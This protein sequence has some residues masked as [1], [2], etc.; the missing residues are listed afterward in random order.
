MV[1]QDK[2][3]A[4]VLSLNKRFDRKVIEGVTRFVHESGHWS[5]FLEDDPTA[6]IPDFRHGHFDG[7]IADLDDPRIPR[8]V[9]GL[10]MPVVGIGGIESGCALNLTVSTV[11]TNNHKIA[12]MAAEYLMRLGLRSFGYCGV[13]ASTID[14]WNRERQETFERQV[15]VAGHAC[16]IFKAR[17]KP[18]HSWEQ[19]QEAI[20]A[21][22]DPL[23]KPVGVLA[24]NDVRARHVLEA[25]RRFGFR[26]PD[27]VAVLGVD[28]D[29]LI[30]DLATPPLSSIVQG[31]EEIGYRAAKL[32]DALMRH[33]AK[34]V[35]NILVDPVTIA[36]RASTDL[37][38]T[39]DRVVADALRL[40]RQQACGGLGVAQVAQGIGVSRSTL[41]G[42]FRQVVGRSVHQEILRVQISAA[43]SLLATTDLSLEDIARRAGFCH[44]Q[45]L[46]AIFRRECGQTPGEFR[47][48]AR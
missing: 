27:D 31:T 29:E 35:T 39:T 26:V 13:P 48:L 12:Q 41:D 42:H 25:C 2:H 18:S 38:A 17:Y 33:Q 44:A 28:N 46:A 20:R 23:P 30:C 40:I 47:R 43:R 3:V 22:L 4:L 14:P 16:A 9:A 36:E 7:V 45:Y 15:T 19:L 37:I 6:K 24:A 21:W 11:G 1:S 34:R 8:Q 5:V 10:A 32:L